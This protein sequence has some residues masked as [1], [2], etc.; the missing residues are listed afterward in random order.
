MFCFHSLPFLDNYRCW[1]CCI[2]LCMQFIN[3]LFVFFKKHLCLK[4]FYMSDFYLSVL[5][6]PSLSP[7][8]Q[9][10]QLTTCPW[11]RW[12]SVPLI[13]LALVTEDSAR[14]LTVI[15]PLL[16][17]LSFLVMSRNHTDVSSNTLT[18]WFLRLFLTILPSTST[19]LLASKIIL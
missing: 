17:V 18:F 5:L 11:L 14:R 6:K 15:L 4:F 10:I 7:C 9:A 2:L 13:S 16:F 1:F 12:S 8:C 3:N 19:Q